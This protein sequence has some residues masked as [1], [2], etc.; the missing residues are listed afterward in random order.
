MAMIT[1]LA[2]ELLSSLFVGGAFDE[3]VRSV[4]ELE[5]L[6]NRLE[7]AI[8]MFDSGDRKT[9][10]KIR[11]TKLPLGWQQLATTLLFASCLHQR[12]LLES[13]YIE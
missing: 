11:C 3:A 4:S 6:V 7:E 12:R 8:A 13:T 2:Q 9:I 5:Q 10:S 1:G